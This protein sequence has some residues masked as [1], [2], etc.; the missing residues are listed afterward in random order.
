MWEVLD[1]DLKYSEIAY[2]SEEDA[3]KE[4]IFTALSDDVNSEL[5]VKWSEMKS[6]DEGGSSYLFLML[7][8]AMLAL[9][10]FN[11]WRKVRKRN[12]NQY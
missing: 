1:E 8:L 12:R 2:P 4:K 6:Y 3:A 11:I 9:A 7:L 5:D 10:C